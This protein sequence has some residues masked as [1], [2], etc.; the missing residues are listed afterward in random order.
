MSNI[1]VHVWSLCVYYDLYATISDEER[2]MTLI[3]G[4][5]HLAWCWR[6]LSW[7]PSWVHAWWSG[8]VFTKLHFLHNLW[9]GAML[10]G[11]SL[12]SHSVLRLCNTLAY[13]AQSSVRKKMKCCEHFV[14]TKLHFLYNLWMDPICYR[15]CPW[16]TIP[17]SS[18]V[19]F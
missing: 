12:A 7:W 3:H 19:T 9:M 5:S 14:F 16:Q 1:L 4:R 2:F 6:K 10:E 11:L 18:Y 17:F 15:V 8:V 13:W